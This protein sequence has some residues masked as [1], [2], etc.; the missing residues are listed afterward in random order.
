MA[1]LELQKT[2]NLSARNCVFLYAQYLDEKGTM[3]TP[4]TVTKG[5]DLEFESGYK[6]YAKNISRPTVENMELDERVVGTLKQGE[7]DAI[8]YSTPSFYK[9][10]LPEHL[11]CYT[12]QRD[13]LQKLTD[14]TYAFTLKVLYVYKNLCPMKERQEYALKNL[15]FLF[16]TM[17]L[18]TPT[19]K[20]LE[21]EYR[22]RATG[23]DLTLMKNGV[24]VHIYSPLSFIHENIGKH[25][26]NLYHPHPVKN[27]KGY[28]LIHAKASMYITFLTMLTDE[29]TD[30]IER[31]CV[32]NLL[33]DILSEVMK[34][35]ECGKHEHC[36][37]CKKLVASKEDLVKILE[38]M[39]K[40]WV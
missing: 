37:H 13:Q 20:G 32:K 1:S 28:T 17:Y 29:G 38:A 30:M 34:T 23:T 19:T 31:L 22:S 21:A 10:W 15:H 6:I 7:L 8:K 35:N 27:L 12:Q 33:S 11:N 5:W 40:K 26:N 4:T 3:R 36:K 2:V 14:L 39:L 25:V 24:F 18:E 16:Y 9:E